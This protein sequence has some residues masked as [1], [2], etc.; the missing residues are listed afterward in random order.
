MP[1]RRKVSRRDFIKGVALTGAAT[2]VSGVGTTSHAQVT[3]K[4]QVFKVENCPVHDGALR[5]VGLDCLLN[6]LSDFDIK[7]YKTASLH[8]WGSATG[9]IAS[10]DVV[11]ITVAGTVIRGSVD[12]ISA[13][14]RGT[15]GVRVIRLREGDEVAAAER[16]PAAVV[17]EEAEEQAGNGAAEGEEA[18]PSAENTEQPPGAPAEDDV[19]PE[20]TE[21]DQKPEPKGEDA[22][23]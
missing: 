21:S 15:K 6:L 14:G 19:A 3:T 9:I 1:R 17:R 20:P 8:K 11:L 2:C 7:L 18:P 4:S 13:V 22:A 12:T 5:H 23:E 10:D 16:I